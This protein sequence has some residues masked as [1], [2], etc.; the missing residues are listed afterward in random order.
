MVYGTSGAGIRRRFSGSSGEGIG[1]QPAHPSIVF[2]GSCVVFS[3]R[4]LHVVQDEFPDIDV[5]RFASIE[6][7]RGLNA[8]ES[9]LVQVV[10]VDETVAKGLV[11]DQASLLTLS[12]DVILGVGYLSSELAL[13]IADA[14]AERDIKIRCLPMR[15]PVDAWIAAFRLMVLGEDF[16]PAEVLEMKEAVQSPKLHDIAPGIHEA[17]EE[18]GGLTSDVAEAMGRLTGREQEILKL[19]SSGQPNKAIARHLGLSEHT[20]KLHVHHIFGKIGVR[21]R[22]GASHWYLSQTR[23]LPWEKTR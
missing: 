20:I 14:M 3:D 10:V 9:A 7:L 15:C 18:P 17:A 4:L 6:Q 16:V 11:R 23:G 8:G 5:L 19:M 2:V 22:T 12:P 1:E 21:N 13:V